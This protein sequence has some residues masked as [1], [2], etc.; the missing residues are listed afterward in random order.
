MDRTDRWMVRLMA[1]GACWV[2]LTN[3]HVTPAH[4]GLVWGCAALCVGLT[5]RRGS[6]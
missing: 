3:P 6:R 1:A 4:C 5:F 2:A